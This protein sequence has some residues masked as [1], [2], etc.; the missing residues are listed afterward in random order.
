[1]DE[2]FNGFVFFV[3]QHEDLQLQ[4]DPVNGQVIRPAG[5]P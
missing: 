3:D 4:T 2:M 1:V 5:G